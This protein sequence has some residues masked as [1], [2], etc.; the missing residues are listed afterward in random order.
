MYKKIAFV[1]ALIAP[2]S[3]CV[4][5]VLVGA[6]AAAGT[7]LVE[8]DPRSL[9]TLQQDNQ[10]KKQAQTLIYRDPDLQQKSHITVAV[11]N[12]VALMVGQVPNEELRQ[13]AYQYVTGVKNIHQVY[14]QVKISGINSVLERSS[15]TWLTSKV[16]S[17]LIATK[18]VPS[19]SIKVITENGIVYLMGLV[20]PRQADLAVTT[21][22]RVGGVREVVKVF[23]YT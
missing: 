22:R 16:K 7:T 5:V 8:K 15:D 23:Q 19:N 1:L 11:F 17:E 21:A 18:G 14:N 3:S 12:H 4:P 2:L 13:R 10:A 20:T 6:G 9:N